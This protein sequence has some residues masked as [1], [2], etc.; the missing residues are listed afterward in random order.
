MCETYVNNVLILFK[1]MAQKSVSRMLI[2]KLIS[3]VT[4]H[5]SIFIIIIKIPKNYNY[6]NQNIIIYLVQ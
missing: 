4:F 5:I 6:I 2:Q 1:I 3:E